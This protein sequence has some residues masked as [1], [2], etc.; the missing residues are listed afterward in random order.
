MRSLRPSYFGAFALVISSAVAIAAA[1]GG[2]D[3][4]PING[5]TDAASGTDGTISTEGDGGAVGDGAASADAEPDGE[6]ITDGG[7]NLDPDA[8]EDDAGAACNTLTNDAPAIVSS[9]A[10]IA[11]TLGG[12][13][14][15]AG[16]YFLVQVTAL[17][18]P[19]FCQN[20]FIPVSVKQTIDLTVAGNGIGTAQSITQIAS[21]GAR[22]RTSTLDP[23]DIGSGSPLQ[24][25]QTCPPQTGTGPVFYGSGLRNS[26]QALALRL[27]Y[28]SGQAIY[29]YEK[30]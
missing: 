1:C 13:A 20:Q 14:L 24:A 17:G 9:C 28:G 10:S 29:L 12:G 15:V 6:V 16:K 30:Q 19:G 4:V 25:T 8:G 18:T 23:A 22:R 7:G 2:T 11:P 5:A 27:P 26:K 21:G 3:E